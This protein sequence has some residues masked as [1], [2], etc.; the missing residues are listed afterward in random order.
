MSEKM[1]G[2]TLTEDAYKKIELIEQK[3]RHLSLIVLGCLLPGILGLG[4]NTFIVVAYSHQKGGLSENNIL[5]IGALAMVCIALLGIAIS[6]FV[7]LKKLGN[8]L[9][10]IEALEETIYSE[11]LKTTR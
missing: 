11:V 6:R 10:Q 4:L 7:I 3:K 9:S 5:M 8:K 2:S 1:T